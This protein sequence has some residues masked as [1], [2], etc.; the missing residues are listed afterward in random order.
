MPGSWKQLQ[1]SLSLELFEITVIRRMHE[2][3]RVRRKTKK[4][5]PRRRFLKVKCLL[6][7]KSAS[8]EEQ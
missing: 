1:L 6:R 5:F 2:G 8:L 4:G 7:T 3:R